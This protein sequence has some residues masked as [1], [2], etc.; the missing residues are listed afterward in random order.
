MAGD[1]LPL[2]V[3]AVVLNVA[4]R[5]TGR[6]RTVGIRVGPDAAITVSAPRRLP[7]ADVQEMV[8]RRA[9]WIA[10]Q[11]ARMQAAP[12]VL[13]R[14]F[15]TGEAVPFLGADLALEVIEAGDVGAVA[16]RIGSR[17]VVT[18]PCGRTEAVRCAD[19]RAAVVAHYTAEAA[20]TLGARVA[21]YCGLLGVGVPEIRIRNQ[22]RRWGSCDPRGRLYLNWRLMMMP[23][24]LLEYVVVHEVCHLRVAD[25]SPRFW[26]LV[27]RLAPNL[28]QVKKQL[29]DRGGQFTL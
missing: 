13:R 7:L 27:R 10:R 20:A 6:T 19:V 14:R 25:H 4:I 29:R 26:N 2:R 11:V 3:G 9:D 23:P 17:L 28:D 8:T 22:Q 15:V 5:R 16:R 18:V 1:F 12:P 21:H 24:E